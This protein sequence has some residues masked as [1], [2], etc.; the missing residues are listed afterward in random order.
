MATRRARDGE[1]RLKEERAHSQE[2]PLEERDAGPGYREITDGK[3]HEAEPQ[4]GEAAPQQM[5][6]LGEH[7]GAGGEERQ[8]RDPDIGRAVEE[9]E[10]H[11]QDEDGAERHQIRPVEGPVAYRHEREARHDHGE[12]RQ[13]QRHQRD[14]DED[15]LRVNRP[16]EPAP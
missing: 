11:A 4:H 15:G 12:S 6:P 13:M 14:E 16:S 3:H 9:V 8:R 1:H 2:T 5:A 7:G 10:Q